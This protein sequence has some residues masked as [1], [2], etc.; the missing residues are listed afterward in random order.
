MSLPIIFKPKKKFKLVRLGKNHDGGYLVGENSIK[1][2]DIL[3]SFGINDDW[4]FEKDFIDKKPSL[5]VICYDDKPIL[6]FLFKK[7]IISIVFVLSNFRFKSITDYVLK[8]FDYFRV[9][10]KIFFKK[11]KISYRDLDQIL[12][13][14]ESKNIFLK[15]DIEGFEYRV[16]DEILKNQNKFAG[17]IIEFHDV[18]YHVDLISKF[19]NSLDLKLVHIHPNNSSLIDQNNNPTILEM[20]F[21]KKDIVLN[22]DVNLPHELDMKNDPNKEDV[23]LNFK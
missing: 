13:N 23:L 11:K 22:D 5:K 2:S 7:L 6:K 4:S 17:M 19:I 20:T 1:N 10:K 8:I 3:I 15:I 12:N 9:K 18:D 16:I 14:F 21:E